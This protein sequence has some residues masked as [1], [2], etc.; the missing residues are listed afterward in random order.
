MKENSFPGGIYLGVTLLHGLKK[1]P[2]RAGGRFER[3]HGGWAA[4]SGE[5]GSRLQTNQSNRAGYFGCFFD[6]EHSNSPS[7][8]TKF[9]YI[10]PGMAFAIRGVSGRFNETQRFSS[11][12]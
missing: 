8:P 3:P 5:Q 4:G 7:W 1:E 12:C 9:K 2:R 11:P 10:V 6:G